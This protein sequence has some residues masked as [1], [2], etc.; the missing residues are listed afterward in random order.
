MIE[1]TETKGLSNILGFISK[2]C[3]IININPEKNPKIQ[4][5]F[6]RNF[7]R[8]F[9]SSELAKVLSDNR[10]CCDEYYFSPK[11]DTTGGIIPEDSRGSDTFKN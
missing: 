3:L 4:K 1:I 11:P 7:E 8:I 6:D 2:V 5:L 10:L 9:P